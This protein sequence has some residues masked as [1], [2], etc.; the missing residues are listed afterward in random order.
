[1]HYAIAFL[2][3]LLLPTQ[4]PA[5][6]AQA[7]PGIPEAMRLQ[8]TDPAGAAK[9]L[10]GVTMREPQNARAWRLLG[11]ALQQAEQFDRAIEAYQK[12][13]AL[14]PDPTSTFNIG[15]THLRKKSVDTAFEWLAKAKAAKYDVTQMLVDTNL[16]PLRSDPRYVALLLK[17]P[18]FENPFVEETKILAE[19]D[20]EAPNDQ[21]GWIARGAGDLDKDGVVDFV[22]CA[23]FTGDPAR[24]SGR[25]YAYSTKSRKLLWKVDGAPG[26]QLGITLETAGDINAD[27]TPDVVATGGGKANV[28]SGVD[29]KVL[30][31]LASPGALPI[32]AG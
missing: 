16:E 27:G 22:T 9:I 28:F 12:A 25:V 3:L 29:G 15:I 2:L 11:G 4:Q 18:D 10:E 5:A 19:W 13:L 31:S 7:P 32:L 23:P 30:L 20:G 6:P 24:P 8:A 17:K 14:G 21:F 26:D 1:M